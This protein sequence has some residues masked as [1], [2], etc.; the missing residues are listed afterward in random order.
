MKKDIEVLALH[1]AV[2]YEGKA[3]VGTVIGALLGKHPDLKDKVKSLSK[4]VQE[5]VKK[6][7]ALSLDEQ[8]DR[9][10]TIAPEEAE[11]KREK[12]KRELPEL[13]NVHGTVVTRI[14]PEPSKYPHIG[15][16]LSFLIN[17]LYA[18]KYNGKCVL[19]FDDTNPEKAQKEYYDA[20]HDALDWLNIKPNRT[21][22]ASEEMETFYKYAEVLIKKERAYVCFCDK[23]TVSQYRTKAMICSHR[24][25]DAHHNMELWNEMLAAKYKAGDVVL[26][27]AGEI[28]ATN[29]TLRDPVLFRIVTTSHPLTKNK[30]IVWPTYD[31]ETVIGEEIAG[32]THILRSNEFGLMRVELQNY[33]KDLL[34]FKKQ[35]VIQYGRFN[36]IGAE[37]QGRVIRE[38]IEKKEVTGW[39]DPR[40]VTIMALR[41]RGIVP[42]TLHELAIEVGL[43]STETNLDWSMIAAINRKIIDPVTKR[44][45]VVKNPKKIKIEHPLKTVDVPLHP[46]NKKLG[47]KHIALRDTFYVSDPI[48]K[49]NV[50]RFMHMFNFKDGKFI[51]EEYDH[52]L[53]AKIIHAVPAHD[54]LDVRVLMNDGSIIEGKGEKALKELKD[55]EIV[56]FERMFFCRLDDKEKMLFVYAHP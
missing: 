22:I 24:R 11:E 20:V 26:R 38:L 47:K 51:S 53:G 31:F 29:A 46:E 7:N 41:R 28:D 40:L 56:Q 23:E 35:D 39:D 36:V 45:F 30:Y 48:E 2:K 3:N 33:I 55:G 52:S 5:I 16:A 6:V 54:A 27:L 32:V 43:S 1:N 18:K 13:P 25:Q 19:R 14:P 42:E 17:Y 12:K 49:G 50:Y 4:D 44:Y 10:A 9:L 21:I 37:T 34:G 15:H 8:K